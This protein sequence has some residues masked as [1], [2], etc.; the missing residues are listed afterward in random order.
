MASRRASGRTR[1]EQDLPKLLAGRRATLGP[2]LS[3]PAHWPAPGPRG[4]AKSGTRHEHRQSGAGAVKRRPHG[5]PQIERFPERLHRRHRYGWLRPGEWQ[6][7]LQPVRRLPCAERNEN[8]EGQTAEPAKATRHP[9]RPHRGRP[10]GHCPARQRIPANRRHTAGPERSEEQHGRPP[11]PDLL[12]HAD[13]RLPL[14]PRENKNADA[15][16]GFRDRRRPT[17]AVLA[18]GPTSME[19]KA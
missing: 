4:N 15:K 5:P 8:A 2:N 18:T 9:P 11:W 13:T 17:N 12:Q 1:H 19:N 14:V 3:R 10:R 6:H 7:V 16:R